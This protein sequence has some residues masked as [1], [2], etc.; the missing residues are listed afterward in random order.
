M[1]TIKNILTKILLFI[2]LFLSFNDN[3]LFVKSLPK[4]E[5]DALVSLLGKTGLLVYFQKDSIDG[6]YSFCSGSIN[7]TAVE[8][9]C[10]GTYVTYISME[11]W[12][13]NEIKATDFVDN[14]FKLYFDEVFFLIFSK[15]TM[16]PGF[17][18]NFPEKTTQR[19]YSVKLN[20][21]E[22]S[23]ESITGVIP[24][25]NIY[26]YFN[27][28]I[29]TTFDLG[30]LR[31]SL[32]MDNSDKTI[33]FPHSIFYT[34]SLSIYKNQVVTLS[35]FAS[36]YPPLGPFLDVGFLT[37]KLMANYDRSSVSNVLNYDLVDFFTVYEDTS[38]IVL[39][40]IP[41]VD[42]MVNKTMLQ[43]FYFVGNF[44]T[45]RLLDYSSFTILYGIGIVNDNY[46]KNFTAPGNKFPLSGLPKNL[47]TPTPGSYFQ[48]AG[49]GGVFSSTSDYAVFKNS[50]SIFPF[51]SIKNGISGPLPSW[52]TTIKS[53]TSLDFSLNNLT[54][55][56]D[57]S[58]CSIQSFKIDN[59]YLSGPIPSCMK[60]YM[61]S[62][63]GSI[64]IKGNRFSNNNN[65]ETCTSIIPSYLVV[66][67]SGSYLFG[68]D[69]GF[70]ASYI[71]SVPSAKWVVNTPSSIL[72][73]SYKFP[74]NSLVSLTFSIINK[75]LVVPVNISSPVFNSVET[76][77]NEKI[78]FNGSYFT[79]N[80]S[81]IEI[82]LYDKKGQSYSCPVIQGDSTFSTISCNIS[83]FSQLKDESNV[84]VIIKIGIYT[85]QLSIN[86]GVTN[87][88]ILMCSKDQCNQN[89]YC[90]TNNATCTCNYGF[91]G[92]P[93][94]TS[95][96]YD[97][98]NDC[99]ISNGGGSC[100]YSTGICNCYQYRG[101]S[102]C[103]EIQ[104][105]KSCLNGGSCDTTN[106]Q[107]KCIGNYIGDDCSS[108]EC[109]ENCLNGGT[110]NPSNGECQCIDGYFGDDC[111]SIHCKND[112]YNGGTCDTT[113][114]Q[115]KC[116]DNYSGDN[117]T[118]VQC[119]ENCFN[120]GSCD[121]T[122]GECKCSIDYQG[123]DC[124]IPFIECSNS[125]LNGGSCINETGE[126][127]C[128]IGYQGDDCS[129]KSCTLNSCL[130]GGT[131][132][133]STKQCQ[134][135]NGYQGDD[136]SILQCSN[137]CLNGGSCNTTIGQCK[138]SEGYQGNDC[139]LPFIECSNICGDSGY[140]NNQ[141][142]ICEC[143]TIEYTSKDCSIPNHWVSAINE[144]SNTGG[145]V[146]LYGW[147]GDIHNNLTIII[148]QLVCSDPIAIDN[149]TITCQLPAGQSGI[150]N[151]NVTQ[152]QI[153]WIGKDLFHYLENDS[154]I[155]NVCLNDCNSKGVCLPWGECRCNDGWKGLDCNSPN[156]TLGSGSTNT[157]VD[158]NGKTT[159]DDN[160]NSYEIF[161]D[162][163]VELDFN[164]HQ[165]KVYN[166]NKKWE[167]AINLTN[168]NS[169]QLFNQKLDDNHAELIYKVEIID[170]TKDY[171]F[172]DI[173]YRLE[174]DSIKVSIF[175]NNYIYSSTLNTLQLQ[176]VSKTEEKEI[177]KDECN[178]KETEIESS[179]NQLLNFVTVKKDNKILYG[180]FINKVISDGR[181]TYL[182]TSVISS[183]Q[184]K[185]TV[186]MGM[187]LP[188]CRNCIIDPDFSL[189]LTTNFKDSCGEDDNRKSYVIPVAVVASFVG[190]A[191]I[192]A[193]G[194]L[195]YR[196]KRVE[197]S[198][199][200][201]RKLAKN[202]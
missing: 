18:G 163:L 109:I 158:E 80:A 194:F 106:G 57:D 150:Q 176:M 92:L 90:L 8:I 160:Y 46:Y 89:S 125:C 184:T 13:Q 75:V 5:H 35:I 11:C 101:G 33:K 34:N 83:N 175:I 9:K 199:S 17:L 148:G 36:N 182:R 198:Q 146:T 115:C 202:K 128:L 118:I 185:S 191:A 43:S 122:K 61:Q 28:A 100:N 3:I 193:L 86:F 60:C 166:L 177:K 45:D 145:E 37:L 66:N 104:C 174:K 29:S 110:C 156:T 41:P 195:A 69:L 137:R 38:T 141:T 153:I 134:C 32:Q 155:N 136:C 112:C 76:K 52:D 50:A 154:K 12:L 19:I 187:N 55:T 147:F 181:S 71:T 119:K 30:L 114:G 79:Y 49:I 139:S 51:N 170:E 126:C 42:K 27:K 179:S 107:C 103:S 82:N 16:E 23:I 78:I 161:I 97:C 15:C 144:T 26:F 39:S 105:K 88:P 98:L 7:N 111:S 20:N 94:C 131:C 70:N 77:T 173:T 65:N 201:L 180:R 68:K 138:C 196:K 200:K 58:F 190:V 93:E 62:T 162:K 113:K 53:V 186:T 117:C 188:H 133:L 59:N 56:L 152:N 44:Y 72:Y 130:N 192:G 48:L 167:K 140:C 164:G 6:E 159:I 31:G 22:N 178:N 120:G 40:P 54:G 165:V 132:D 84:K 123:S 63:P 108:F 116:I 171:T 124:S 74:V 121:T 197:V 73:T 95:I 47:V 10:D 183:D 99:S 157:D 151:V 87:S 14:F 21:C 169:V 91:S 135:I 129:S 127:S 24:I 149:K 172:S 2:L 168:S 96:H 143:P 64:T 81:V 142:G 4:G 1:V 102:D 85:N 25:K 67:S 189:L